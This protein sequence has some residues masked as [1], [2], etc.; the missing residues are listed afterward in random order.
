MLDTLASFPRV[1]H[2]SA[3]EA[4]VT[5]QRRVLHISLCFAHPSDILPLAI[6][7]PPWFEA[8]DSIPQYDLTLSTTRLSNIQLYAQHG[9]RTLRC[10]GHSQ[11]HGTPKT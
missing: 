4:G 11:A 3:E 1:S 8:F 9:P 10:G 6:G 2:A 7:P 5:A